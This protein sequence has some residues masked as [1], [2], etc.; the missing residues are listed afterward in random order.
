MSDFVNARESC[1][2]DKN[3]TL[4]A[5]NCRRNTQNRPFECATGTSWQESASLKRSF[6]QGTNTS[7]ARRG[8]RLLTTDAMTHET[9]VNPS[10]VNIVAL[11][12]EYT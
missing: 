4:N 5:C 1:V 2:S 7:S 9:W 6:H 11:E 12:E 8:Q 3:A 10:F